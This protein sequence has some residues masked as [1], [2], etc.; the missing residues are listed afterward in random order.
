[1]YKTEPCLILELMHE[2]TAFVRAISDDTYKSVIQ[3]FAVKV[4]KCILCHTNHI[5]H[6][7]FVA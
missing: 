2:I 1:M 5:E 7:I 6:N 4:R 3:N